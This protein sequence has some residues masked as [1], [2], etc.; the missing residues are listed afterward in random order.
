VDYS[1]YDYSNIDRD[2]DFVSVSL[3]AVYVFTPNIFFGG[4]VTYTSTDSSED[5]YDYNKTVTDLSVSY[6]F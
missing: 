6:T 1:K 4:G 5:A 2:D 3:K